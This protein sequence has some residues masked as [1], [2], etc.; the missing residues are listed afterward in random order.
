MS[1]ITKQP[2]IQLIVVMVLSSFAACM[3]LERLQVYI[4]WYWNSSNI[5]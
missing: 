5:A 3:V 2:T 1:A 4:T